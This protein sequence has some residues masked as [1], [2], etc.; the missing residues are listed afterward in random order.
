MIEENRLQIRNQHEK[1]TEKSNFSTLMTKRM[2]IVWVIVQSLDIDFFYRV[3][4]QLQTITSIYSPNF[5]SNHRLN[6]VFDLF[7]TEKYL[8]NIGEL[9]KRTRHV[10]RI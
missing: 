5:R 3:L 2:L 6:K 7:F 10:W 4:S 9:S 1:I 8:Y